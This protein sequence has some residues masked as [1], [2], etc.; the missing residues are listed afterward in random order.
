[1]DLNSIL[2][3]V[4]VVQAG[5]FSEAARRLKMPKTTVSARVAALEAAVGVNLIQRTTRK[6][7][8]TLA[9]MGYFSHCVKAIQQLDAGAAE[10]ASVNDA[11]QGTLRI[12]APVDIGHTILPAIVHSFLERC[13]LVQVEMLISNRVVDLVG[14]GI[15]LAMRAGPMKDS[16][17]VSKRFFELEANLWASPTYL[18]GAG[19]LTMPKDLL[20]HQ[21]VGTRNPTTVQ[22]RKGKATAEV[23]LSGRALCDDYSAIKALVLLGN[24]IGW[25]PN[26]LVANEVANG[27]LVPVLPGWTANVNGDVH[28][29]YPGMKRGSANVRAFIETAFDVVGSVHLIDSAA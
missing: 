15:D 17:L 24:C 14:E 9:G 28:F 7:T 5:S 18:A 21:F 20:K 11:P 22:L 8:V 3:F 27:S 10:L 16:S 25:L 4:K 2:V 1:M 13:P 26:F 23:I 6:L 29:V 12:T 19:T